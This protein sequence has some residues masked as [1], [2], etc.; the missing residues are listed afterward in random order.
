MQTKIPENLFIFEMANNHMGDLNH[1]LDIIQKFAKVSR[2]YPEFQ[3]G[4]KLQYRDFKT[5]LHPSMI[6]R[7]D[8]KYIKRFSET[9]LEPAQ[10]ETLIA[11]IKSE[12]LLAIS[13][14]FDEPSVD[15]IESQK[16]DLIKIA[17]CSFNDWPLLERVVES[18]LPIIASTAGATTAQIDNVVSFLMHRQKDFAILHCV[19]EYPTADKQLNLNQIDFLKARYPSVKVGFSTHENPDNTLAIQ[20]AIAKGAQIFEK[21][22]GVATSEYSLND[23]SASPDQVGNWL[24]AA[25]A[26]IKLSGFKERRL[27]SNKN[28]SESLAALRR[29]IFAKRNIASG[30]TLKRDDVYFAFPPVAEQRTADHWSKYSQL[31][32]QKNITKDEAISTKNT[33]LENTRAAVHS[34]AQKVKSIISESNV[35]I[36]NGA[37]LELSHHYGIDQ[38]EKVGLALITVVNREYCKKI[39][40]SLP[41]QRH[42]EQFHQ[43]K[44]ETFH[45]L[46]GE[47]E[48]TLDGETQVYRPGSVLHVLPGT[49][50]AF[51]SSTG[52]VM[53]EVSS[54]HL[55]SDSYYSDEAINKNKNRKTLL[56]YWTD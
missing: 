49:R 21:H 11:E 23:Y 19:G 9:R 42:P 39:L 45:V 27:L 22:V 43:E 3:F 38:F 35:I 18:T 36:P 44:E 30:E 26:A 20:I 52:C 37:T 32:S 53:E 16:L 28:E 7:N 10:F 4:F 14:P 56:T 51:V 12:G 55:T 29:G 50:H 33:S 47:V 15:L 8:L 41:N 25:Q 54:T 46:Y 5:Y 2:N 17:S 13:T 48:I 6:D 24:T 1:G 31:I 40:I 34:A